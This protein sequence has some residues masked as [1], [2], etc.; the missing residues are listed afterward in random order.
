M[1]E[2]PFYN[3]KKRY[4]FVKSNKLCHKC[5]SLK[6]R[7][8]DCI[9]SDVCE[10]KGCFGKFHHTILRYSNK[11]D[12]SKPSSSQDTS[13][14]NSKPNPTNT[15]SCTVVDKSVRSGVYLCVI[16]VTV[17]CDGKE[18]ATYAFLDQGSTHT[19]CE[20]AW[21]TSLASAVLGKIYQFKP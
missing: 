18:F 2:V 21:L 6:H 12:K 8:P 5:L 4:S 10:V 15:T 20:E 13:S 7:T 14:S 11:E 3:G 9:N 16:P 19:F 17:Y 1:Q